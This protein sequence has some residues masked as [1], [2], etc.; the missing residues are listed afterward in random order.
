VE[1][2]NLLR[3]GAS[4]VQAALTALGFSRTGDADTLYSLGGVFDAPIFIFYR[5]AEP[6]TQFAQFRGKRLSIGTPGTALRTLIFQVLTATRYRRA[7]RG[8]LGHSLCRDARGRA[9]GV[10]EEPGGGNERKSPAWR[11]SRRAGRAVNEKAPPTEEQ[12]TGLSN[13]GGE[14]TT[15]SPRALRSQAPVFEFGREIGNDA[16][17]Q[18]RGALIG[19]IRSCS[20]F[21]P[22]VTQPAPPGHVL[23]L[24]LGQCEPLRLVAPCIAI[25]LHGGEHLLQFGQP[26]FRQGGPLVRQRERRCIGWYVSLRR[27]GRRSIM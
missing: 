23:G 24:R 7:P 19:P 6:I 9:D 2:L 18:P 22:G 4:G 5:N 16:M 12:A 17:R 25:A 20:C 8:F 13:R 11:L 15:H 21:H 14:E 26:S 3:D 27:I 1:D 10:R